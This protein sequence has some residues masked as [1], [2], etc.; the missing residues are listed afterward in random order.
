MENCMIITSVCMFSWGTQLG[1]GFGIRASAN[2]PPVNLIH[3]HQLCEQIN[4]ISEHIQE[5]KRIGYL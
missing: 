1:S 5:I 2:R 4:R 3:N